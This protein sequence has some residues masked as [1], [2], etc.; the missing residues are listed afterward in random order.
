MTDGTVVTNTLG[1]RPT[2]LRDYLDVVRRRKWIILGVPVVAA[3]VALAFTMTQAPVYGAQASVLVNRSVG[4]STEITGIDPSTADPVRYLSTQAN[5]ARSPALAARVADAAGVPRLT[6]AAVL[7][8]SSV[9]PRPDADVLDFFVTH[10]NATDAERIANAYTRE[11]TRYKTELD[12]ARIQEAL[13]ALRARLAALQ[14]RG[15]GAS[16]TAQTLA[17]YESQLVT[18]AKLVANSTTVLEPADGA[19]QTSPSPKRNLAVAIMLGLVLGLG[20][21]FVAEALDRRA[22]TEEEI[23]T[24][25]GLPLLGRIPT[26]SRAL[27]NENQLVMMADPTN[28][29]AESFRKLRATIES[30]NREHGTRTLMFTSA[31]KGEGKSTT[32]ANAAVTFARAGRRVVLVDLDVRQPALHFFFGARN[33]RGITDALADGRPLEHVVQHVPLPPARPAGGDRKLRAATR[34][35]PSATTSSSQLWSNGGGQDRQYLDF[36]ACGSIPAIDDAFLGSER[37]GAALAT[38]VE[39]YDIV[40]LDA[41]PF[42]AVGDAM[43]LSEKV[44]GIVVVANFGTHRSILRELARE[45]QQSRARSLGFV[46]TG[47]SR[48]DGNGYGYGYG[49]GYEPQRAEFQ[50]VTAPT[51]TRLTRWAADEE[52]SSG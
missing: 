48:G 39:R 41:P 13:R 19:V 22:R 26:P 46:L 30:V 11:F 34:W 35:G 49:Y 23:A 27:R 47:T 6:S 52:R 32:I 36:I 20:L 29:Q 40:L 3:A 37:V 24:I 25:L 15:Q 43:A 21:A 42:L 10:G 51:P 45:L 7:A 9:E 16:A 28:A 50:A 8:M 5:V 14:D 17:Q 44:D 18:A 2:N 33:D 12:T 38:L 1:H 4:V 31:V